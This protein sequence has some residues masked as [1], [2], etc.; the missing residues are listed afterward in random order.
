MY[1]VCIVC[2]ANYCRSPVAEK[3]FQDKFKDHYFFSAGFEPKYGVTMD[4]RSE[5][6]LNTCGITDTKHMPRKITREIISKTDLVFAVD[7]FILMNLNK[8]FPHA[9][10]KIKL[11]TYQNPK[12]I[13]SDPYNLNLDQYQIVMEDIKNAVDSIKF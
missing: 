6:Y 10:E 5:N 12:I 13:L 9:K 2:F 8:V 7:A 11:L 1:S 3:L 4:K